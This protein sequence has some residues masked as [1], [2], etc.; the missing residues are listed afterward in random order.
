MQPLL[1]AL[2]GGPPDRRPALALVEERGPGEA[3]AAPRLPL[4]DPDGE[5]VVEGEADRVRAALRELD[6]QAS[7][8]SQRGLGLGE[9]GLRCWRDRGKAV[10]LINRVRPSLM[11]SALNPM[12]IR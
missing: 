11:R 3:S 4:V 5:A 8:R 2:K 10:P 6:A 12:P 1:V 7:P 9:A